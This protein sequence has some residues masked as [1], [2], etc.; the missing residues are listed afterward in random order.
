VKSQAGPGQV[1]GKSW[2][3]PLQ[4]PVKSRTGPKQVVT[5]KKLDENL[6]TRNLAKSEK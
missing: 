2:E 6:S 1:P 4:V 3:S 5:P